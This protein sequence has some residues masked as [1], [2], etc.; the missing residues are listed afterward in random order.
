MRLYGGE[1]M[2]IGLEARTGDRKV[3]AAYAHWSFEDMELVDLMQS[4][5][6]SYVAEASELGCRPPRG[7]QLHLRTL[8]DQIEA[9]FTPW[10]CRVTSD[11]HRAFEGG[12]KTSSVRGCHS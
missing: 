6:R 1:E 5:A 12:C 10:F 2:E 7:V 11:S 4:V 8:L 3:L 9:G